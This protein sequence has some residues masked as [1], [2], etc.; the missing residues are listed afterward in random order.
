MAKSI[1]SISLL[2]IDLNQ[3]DIKNILSDATRNKVESEDAN[4]LEMGG[5]SLS[6]VFVSNLLKTKFNIKVLPSVL[7]DKQATVAT[8]T[9]AINNAVTNDNGI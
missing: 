7:F 2:T 6:A 3:D 1:L 9:E 5:D 4:F 8:I